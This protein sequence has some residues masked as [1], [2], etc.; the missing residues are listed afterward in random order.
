MVSQVHS[1]EQKE[2]TMEQTGGVSAST[3]LL[4]KFLK[5]DL[6]GEISHTGNIGENENI[7]KEKVHTNVHYC[8][9]LGQYW[10]R[11]NF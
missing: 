8:Q 4:N 5:I 11:K 7:S 2:S 6:K 10:K 9:N 1:F 3:S